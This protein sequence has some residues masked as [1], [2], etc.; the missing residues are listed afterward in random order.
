[1]R[2]DQHDPRIAQRPHGAALVGREVGQQP[3]TARHRAGVLGD[4]DLSVGHEQVRALVY[5]VL[6]ELLAGRERDR[7]RPCLLV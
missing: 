2:Q 4:L 6:L 3:A 7:D 5:L 1:M